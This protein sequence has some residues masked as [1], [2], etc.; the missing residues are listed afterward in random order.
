M[1]E[2][3]PKFDEYEK[4]SYAAT[5]RTA[6]TL[7]FK[8]LLLREQ[9]KAVH[10]MILQCVPT[11]VRPTL[12]TPDVNKNGYA[13]WR[14]LREYYIGDE[15]NYLQTLET[16]FQNV[17]WKDEES[18]IEFESRYQTMLGE[19]F[20]AGVDKEE[21][22]K[23]NR[24]MSAIESSHH[25]DSRGMHVFDR[26]NMVARVNESKKF[27][28][29]L[30]EIRTEAQRIENGIR[31]Q[32]NK[33][34]SS[35]MKRKREDD[36]ENQVSVKEASFISNTTPSHNHT[37]TTPHRSFTRYQTTRNHYDRNIHRPEIA[38][39]NWQES[40][41]CSYGDRCKF[42]HDNNA[43][44]HSKVQGGPNDKYNNKN[45]NNNTGQGGSYKPDSCYEFIA[46]GR[47]TRRACRFNH[48]QGNTNNNYNRFNG[49]QGANKISAEFENTY[50]ASDVQMKPESKS[51][52]SY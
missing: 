3:D 15:K 10:H 47:C 30:R 31:D 50:V 16:N 36:D 5:T 9:Q 12:L 23:K 4:V 35:M 48:S 38:C 32:T 14:A 37:S 6:L 21:H 33:L 49:L 20:A 24:L 11:A 41:T 18:F 39:R 7:S 40:R 26:F 44:A 19:M 29:W 51:K 13:A 34:N 25:K 42:S 28:D 46:T 52:E 1:L 45:N 27:T 2:N 17:K 43:M 8:Q 22:V